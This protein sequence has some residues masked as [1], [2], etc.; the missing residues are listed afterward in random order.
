MD[1]KEFI[2]QMKKI[3]VS[4]NSMNQLEKK[5]ITKCQDDYIMQYQKIKF[6]E[7]EHTTY[8]KIGYFDQNFIQCEEENANYQLIKCCTCGIEIYMIKGNKMT[9]KQKIKSKTISIKD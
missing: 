4:L 5:M 8:K 2:A 1:N 3:R 7:C 6:N 9:C